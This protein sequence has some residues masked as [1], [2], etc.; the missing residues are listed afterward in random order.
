MYNLFI[1]M[2]KINSYPYN[3]YY[4][5]SSNGIKYKGVKDTRYPLIGKNFPS[6][7]FYT[8]KEKLQKLIILPFFVIILNQKY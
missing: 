7:S 2:Q 8:H 5:G 6:K 4:M 1:N 3:E